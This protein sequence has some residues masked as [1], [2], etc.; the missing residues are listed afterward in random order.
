MYATFSSKIFRIRGN[1]IAHSP[2]S[3][4]S[5]DP[6]LA[7]YVS[8]PMFLIITPALV[9]WGHGHMTSAQFSDFWNAYLPPSP[10]TV[11]LTQLIGTLVRF[12]LPPPL[13][14]RMYMPPFLSRDF[15]QQHPSP[16]SAPHSWHC[17][18]AALSGPL[19]YA[20]IRCW[21]LTY[22]VE[23]WLNIK[24]EMLL[25]GETYSESH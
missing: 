2:F 3:L 9:F 14:R 7:H 5:L 22:M 12:L 10:V 21:A 25:H 24:S 11:K 4:Q 8:R 23:R 19:D 16:C 15:P 20:L 18:E 13:G 17:S 6:L 1:A